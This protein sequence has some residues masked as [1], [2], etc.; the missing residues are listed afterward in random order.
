MF[1]SGVS[2]TWGQMYGPQTL[3]DLTQWAVCEQQVFTSF[4]RQR[5]G[6]S[7]DNLGEAHLL[8]FIFT[9]PPRKYF[10]R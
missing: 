7:G 10:S 2:H 5:R 1:T 8:T 6:Y 3:L 9:G 4:P